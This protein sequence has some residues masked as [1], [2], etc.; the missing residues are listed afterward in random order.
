MP[1]DISITINIQ[2]FS[3]EEKKN[4]D[5]YAR[6]FIGEPMRA[7]IVYDNIFLSLSEWESSISRLYIM[8]NDLFV[9]KLNWRKYTIFFLART[10]HLDE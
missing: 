8:Q 9:S 4:N 1:K 5:E 7:N 3:H 6:A 2:L 10:V